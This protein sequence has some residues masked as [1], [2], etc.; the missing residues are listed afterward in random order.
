MMFRLLPAAAMTATAL[1]GMTAGAATVDVYGAVDTGL[2]Y[3]K[4]DSGDTSVTMDSGISKGSRVG[5]I[6]SED[7][8]GGY[9][10]VFNLETGFSL[11]DGSFDNTKN[12]LFNRN[13]YLGVASP[14]G[15]VRFGRQGA[16][17][18]GVNGSIF[19][20]SYTVFGN[21]YKEA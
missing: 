11:D 1:A 9:K 13:A 2:H 12:R 10:I 8:G 15:E 14:Y 16:L 5:L 19:L 20:N 17:G 6:G 7:L 4:A 21:L 18:S 3:V